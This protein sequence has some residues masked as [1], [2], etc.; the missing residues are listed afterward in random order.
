M[1]YR[2]SRATNQAFY[3]SR[4]IISDCVTKDP[5]AFFA[6]ECTKTQ[7]KAFD[8]LL[9]MSNAL[10]QLYPTQ[11][12]IARKSGCVRETVNRLLRPLE[13]KGL[14][15]SNFR[16]KTSC[17]YQISP[18]FEDLNVRRILKPIFKCLYWL[19][20]SILLSREMRSV[21]EC[22]TSNLNI[23]IST[24]GNNLS[25]YINGRIQHLAHE[26]LT[27]AARAAALD[28]KRRGVM[29]KKV[30]KSLNLTERGMAKI[31][32]FPQDA[33]EWALMEM[34]D[35]TKPAYN[36][37]ALYCK[38]C[39]EYC[40]SAKL[41]IDW[42][43]SFSLARQLSPAAAAQDYLVKDEPYIYEEIE[44]PADKPSNKPR[45]DH[46][47][48]HGNRQS[49]GQSKYSKKGY[50]N[51]TEP[52]QYKSWDGHEGPSADKIAHLRATRAAEILDSPYMCSLLSPSEINELS[53]Q[54]M[55]PIIDSS[56]NRDKFGNK[57]ETDEEI[58]RKLK[59]H[60]A[61]LRRP[62]PY[63]DIIIRAFEAGDTPQQ[64]LG[65]MLGSVTAHRV[66]SSTPV[67][68]PH[69]YPGHAQYNVDDDSGQIF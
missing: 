52:P 7:L 10:P 26:R 30:I 17:Q 18:Y 2:R 37:F 29:K 3:S 62:N 38:I 8:C 36:P 68:Q 67:N 58:L 16:F 45:V 15:S 61:T 14:I 20:L 27:Q 51:V 32:A 50:D 1:N 34:K 39:V 57:T 35:R 46:S 19:P 11:S 49:H 25:N 44:V 53:R 12:Y 4:P 66:D 55:G 47:T 31:A 21:E 6:N 59:A 60:S 69:M 43:L 65:Q 40:N 33:R 48:S 13:E 22:H 63:L 56:P 24:A 54:A 23:Y 42:A 64:A 9:G 41:F 28:M 5:L